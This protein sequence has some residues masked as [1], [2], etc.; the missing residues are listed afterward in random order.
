MNHLMELLI[1]ILKII[2]IVVAYFTILLI[3]NKSKKYNFIKINKLNDEY[4]KN[5]LILYKSILSKSEYKHKVKLFNKQNNKKNN[6]LFIIDFIGDI[7]AT[8][9]DILRRQ[10][11]LIVQTN[12]IANNILYKTKVLLRLE[13]SGGIVNGYGLASSQLIRLKNKGIELIISID[14]IAASGGYMMACTANKIIASPFAIVGSIGVV[15]QLPNFNK[16]LNNYGIEFEELTAGNNKRNLTIFGH[17]NDEKRNKMQK[18]IDDVHQLFI[19]FII[20]NRKVVDIKKVSNGQYWFAQNTIDLKLNL[21]DKILTSDE[22]LEQCYLDNNYDI[23][24]LNFSNHIK[25]NNFIKNIYNK[26]FL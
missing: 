24:H 1:F 26:L 11:D 15:S 3:K 12:D 18:E 16:L 25:D 19:N 8:Q 4:K 2:I 5:R 10:I 14:K 9:V 23:Y 17:N 22:Y 20:C 13:S 7:K 21:I 6:I